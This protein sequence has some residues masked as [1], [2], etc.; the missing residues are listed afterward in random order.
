MNHARD[1]LAK[2]WDDYRKLTPQAARIH[3]LLES[4]GENVVN[5][6][7]AL[8]TFSD[9]RTGI[10]RLARP[11]VQSGWRVAGEYD[12]PEKKLNARHYEHADADLPKVFISELRLKDCSPAAAK[13]IASL[14][15]RAPQSTWNRE[16]LALAG[17]PWDLSLAE[18]DALASESEY[19]GWVAAFGF[20]ANHFTVFVNA[21]KT[22]ASLEQLNTPLKSNGFS[23]NASGGEVKGTPAQLLEQSSTLA[24]KVEV[25]FSD[26]TRLIPS[27]YYEFARRYRKPDGTLFQGFVPQSA[28]KIF[29]ST[30]RR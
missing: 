13:L 5:D 26:G 7:I 4:R 21:L 18:Y 30:N 23:L 19:A 8:R 14:L 15:D 6:H 3:Q 16:D 9:A 27:C 10:E 28:N 1:L 2:L 11:F 24:D 29:E 12:F 25:S 22:I 17:R 20:R